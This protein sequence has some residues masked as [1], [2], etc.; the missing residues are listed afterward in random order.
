[1]VFLEAKENDHYLTNDP[2]T[3]DKPE[4]KTWKKDN[5]MVCSQLRNSMEPT[6]V[7]N[8][9]PFANA[10]EVW[11]TVHDQYSQDK[12]FYRIL[13]LY[14][15]ILVVKMGDLLVNIIGNWLVSWRNL[16]CITWSLRIW[17]LLRV[18]KRN[19]MLL[20]FYLAWLLNIFMFDR[21]LWLVIKFL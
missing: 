17:L 14:S 9:M 5:S 11:Q 6:I 18:N 1:M 8:Y 16:N 4:F 20:S 12:F 2:P 21:R 19:F 10:K 7:G 3:R 15:G 13:D